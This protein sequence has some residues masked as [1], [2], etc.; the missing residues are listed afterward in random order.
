MKKASPYISLNRVRHLLAAG[1]VLLLAYWPVTARAQADS[2]KQPPA[3][4]TDSTAKPEEPSQLSP[5]IDFIAVQKPDNTVDLRVAMKAKFKAAAIR[6]AYLKVKFLLVKDTA[7]TELGSVVTDLAGKAVLNCKAEAL[8]PDK[9][10]KLHFKAVYAGNK[11]FE[12]AEGEATVKRARLEITPVKEDS[13]L[14]VTVKLTDL[15]DGKETPVDKTTVGV[16]V[17][18]SF[19]PLK[20]GEGTTDETGTATI[21]IPQQLPGDARGNI[22]LMA[23]L[24][25]NELYGNMEATVTQPWGVAVSDKIVEQPRALWSAHPPIWML[26]TFI[27]LMGTVWGHYLVIVIQL[28]RL[29]KEEPHADAA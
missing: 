7:E 6:L 5:I 16:Y 23:R 10:G 13:L 28:Y 14:S 12:E 20:L 15:A 11:T 19:F 25:E 17:K 8:Q 21:E 26:I 2:A 27:I 22:T 18:R 4:A 24:D 29:R 9:E 3:A 1:C